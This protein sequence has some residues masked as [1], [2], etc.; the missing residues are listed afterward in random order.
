MSPFL[1]ESAHVFS[2]QNPESCSTINRLS[3]F[4]LVLPGPARF[5]EEGPPRKQN[6]PAGSEEGTSPEPAVPSSSYTAKT[7]YYKTVRGIESRIRARVLP[8]KEVSIEALMCQ[9][10]CRTLWLIRL[11]Q[12][13]FIET[14]VEELQLSPHS[15]SVIDEARRLLTAQNGPGLGPLLKDDS[16]ATK[17]SRKIFG[18]APWHRK[19]SGDS[20]ST[21]ASSVRDLLKSGTPPGTPHS[22]ETLNR[23]YALKPLTLHVPS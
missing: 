10:T 13:P 1:T 6:T 3:D 20:M 8:R 4:H 9:A 15:S 22:G 2:L 23:T 7:W 5:D 11:A 19:E 14:I 17:F 21:V 16:A 18:K 12:K